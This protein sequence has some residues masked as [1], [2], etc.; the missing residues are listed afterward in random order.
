[1]D[2]QKIREDIQRRVRAKLPDSVFADSVDRSFPIHSP[3]LIRNMLR[4]MT[5]CSTQ[6]KNTP[7]VKLIAKNVVKAAEK[8]NI[9]IPPDFRKV[10]MQPEPFVFR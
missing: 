2:V 4:V 8:F 5:T 9:K 1:M 10:Y 7:R 6:F 3:S